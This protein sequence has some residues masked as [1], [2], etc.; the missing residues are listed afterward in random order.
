MKI[1]SISGLAAD[2]RLFERLKLNAELVHLAWE[3]I[4]EVD[5]LSEY[6]TKFIDKIDTSKPFLLM[7]A[8]MG[9]MICSELA[10]ALNPKL[11]I[12]LS[13]AET[14][15][16]LPKTYRIAGY[17]D[18]LKHIPKRILHVPDRL[19]TLA[20]GS[21]AKLFQDY[22][23]DIDKDF[24]IKAARLISK[25]DK[26]ISV[27]QAKLKIK[28]NKDYILPYKCNDTILVNGGHSIVYD[29]AEEVSAIINK[30]LNELSL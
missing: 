4:S 27:S 28:G 23:K 25:W 11:V 16:E 20:F 7:G 24:A 14:R 21:R 22:I 12:M 10:E 26:Q 19:V 15:K 1:Y 18:L 6:A 17:I 8:S 9:G 5:S 29:R 30:K 3:D 13:T 2:G